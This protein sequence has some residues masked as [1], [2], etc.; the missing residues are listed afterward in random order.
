MATHAIYRMFSFLQMLHCLY[1]HFRGGG[2]TV[3]V[4][5]QHIG[6]AAKQL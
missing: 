3:F 2:G 4:N 6:L 1:T 5:A